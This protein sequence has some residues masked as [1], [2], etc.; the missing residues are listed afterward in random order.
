M[1][2]LNYTAQDFASSLENRRPLVFKSNL[3]HQYNYVLCD[4][5]IT[6]TCVMLM[7]GQ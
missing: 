7:W 5:C 1:A 2:Y 4:R 6:D 3:I